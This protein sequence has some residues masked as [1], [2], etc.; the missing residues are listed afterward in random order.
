MIFLTAW[1]ETCAFVN[2]LAPLDLS[3]LSIRL[4]LAMFIGFGM[5]D[6]DITM[7]SPGLTLNMVLPFAIL[8]SSASGSP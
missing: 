2:I 8:G 7:L 3:L 6:A 5:T 1:P 4:R